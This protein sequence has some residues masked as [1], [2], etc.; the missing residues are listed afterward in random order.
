MMMFTS[1]CCPLQLSDVH[2]KQST[3]S[4]WIMGLVVLNL[5]CTTSVQKC[6]CF[7][8]LSKNSVFN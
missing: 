5:K 6:P 4:D 2:Y 3:Q 1:W 7:P 8:D